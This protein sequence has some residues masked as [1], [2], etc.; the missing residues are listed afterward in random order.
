MVGA[1]LTRIVEGRSGL[2]NPMPQCA[3]YLSRYFGRGTCTLIAGI[4][5]RDWRYNAVEH[6]F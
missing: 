5:R 1:M 6:L 3:I 4:D 2:A